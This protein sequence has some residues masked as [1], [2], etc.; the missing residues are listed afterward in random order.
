M[1]LFPPLALLYEAIRWI[2]KF[3]QHASADESFDWGSISNIYAC[4]TT[5]NISTSTA[6]EGK[7]V[8]VKKSFR[9][10]KLRS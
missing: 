8:D 6:K 2:K 5:D 9:L 4:N 1:F 10:K 7:K 3:I